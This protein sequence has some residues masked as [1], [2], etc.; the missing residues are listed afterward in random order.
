MAFSEE[1][2]HLDV[3][4]VVRETEAAFL[5]RLDDDSEYWIPKSQ[6]SEAD[7]YKEGDEDVSLSISEWVAEQKGLDT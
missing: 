7:K 5:F 6:V 3:A 2:V 4:L 1:W